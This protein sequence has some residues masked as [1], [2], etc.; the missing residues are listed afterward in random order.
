MTS[1]QS[2]NDCGSSLIVVCCLLAF[3]EKICPAN[4]LHPNIVSAGVRGMQN[5]LCLACSHLLNLFCGIFF[6]KE[7]TSGNYFWC[8]LPLEDSVPGE[9][10]MHLF[11]CRVSAA[12]TA[13]KSSFGSSEEGT[14][15]L[16][17]L[18]S[19]SILMR[20]KGSANLIPHQRHFSLYQLEN[21]YRNPQ[22]VKL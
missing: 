16:W 5:T 12:R 8:D 2:F 20:P 19:V 17:R 9:E 22:P 18:G 11:V 15:K 10:G 13:W 1:E 3:L 7:L 4:G 14:Y 21:Y 6:L